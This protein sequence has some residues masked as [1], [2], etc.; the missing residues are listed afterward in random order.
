MPLKLQRCARSFVR[1]NARGDRNRMRIS[2]S[3]SKRWHYTTEKIWERRKEGLT[4]SKA[5]KMDPNGTEPF[6]FVFSMQIGIWRALKETQTLHQ[7]TKNMDVAAEEVNTHFL[8]RTHSKNLMNAP[9]TTE[10]METNTTAKLLEGTRACH[11]AMLQSCS[12]NLNRSYFDENCPLRANR[13]DSASC[14]LINY[15]ILYRKYCYAEMGKNP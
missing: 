1:R 11:H 6:S 8:A 5:V 4:D 2:Y 12:V 9:Y 15:S 14:S 7:I 3:S 10:W 13:S